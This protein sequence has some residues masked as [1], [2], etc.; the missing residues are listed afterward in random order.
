MFAAQVIKAGLALVL[1]F[2]AVEGLALPQATQPLNLTQL[3]ALL[4]ATI[5]TV[6]ESVPANT[7]NITFT[8]Q[9]QIPQHD[10]QPLLRAQGI[11][12][13]R[14]NFLYGPPIAGGPAFPTGVIGIEK[15]A[16]DLGA[17]G[18]DITPQFQGALIDDTVAAAQYQQYDNLMTLDDYVKLYTNNWVHVLPHG[19]D[20][21]VLTNYTDD[22]FFSMERLSNSP[23]AV[24]RLRPHYDT[25]SFNIDDKIAKKIAGKSLN[26][27][28]AEGRLFYA[29]Y[30]DQAALPKSAQY[31]AAC[32]GYFYIDRHSGDFLPLAIRTNVGSNLIYTR[33]DTANDWLL[34]KIMLNVNDFWFSQWNHLAQ[35]HEVVQIAYMAAIRTLS[36]AHPVMA[37]LNRLMHEVFAIQPV[38]EAILFQ[39]GATVD[40]LFPFT[41]Q[42]A[43]DYTTKRYK[44]GGA[45]A[46]ESQYFKSELRARGLIDSPYGPALKHF[47][48]YEDASIIHDAAEKALRAFV[49]SY[50]SSDSAVAH[51]QEIQAWAKEAQGPAAVIDFP[52]I[53]CIDDLVGILT[54]MAHLVSTS[55]HTSNTNELLD[56]SSALPFSPP[57]LSQAPPTSK[58]IAN[59]ADYLPKLDKVLA[60][61][62]LAAVFARS[63]IAGTEKTLLHMFDDAD[64]LSRMNSKTAKA[65]ATFQSEM[66]AFSEEVRGRQ[67]GADG[68][69]QG[70]PFIWRALDPNVVPYYIA[71]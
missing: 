30:R 12:L 58:N 19:P 38:A 64:M 71:T 45:G 66:Q 25:L 50:Y 68:L 24:K 11:T 14:T 10:H 34:A 1:S 70:M 27:L 31:G 57:A 51:D 22:L 17:F 63:A 15:L 48:F 46:V 6:I 29:D 13:K 43:Q 61:F 7:P 9:Y 33:L 16:N 8:G 37:M 20:P 5:Q 47:P 69:S 28:F 62:T 39:P 56:V 41:G 53:S 60:Q 35:T 42:S 26:Q 36:E 40:Q 59:V 54:H 52:S 67:F 55:H 23:Y 32:D 18:I 3:A 49:E 65:A 21:G 44:T 2:G 4:Q